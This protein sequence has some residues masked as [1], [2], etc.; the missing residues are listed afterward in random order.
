MKG[1]VALIF[2]IIALVII[3]G[4]AFAVIGLHEGLSVDE[5]VN[6][7]FHKASESVHSDNSEGSG[8]IVSQS[9]EENSQQGEGSYRQENY[10]DGGFR[11]FDTKT[12]EL[13]GS[14]YQS[15]Q[16]KLPSLE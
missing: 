7:I 3:M 14:S 12:G 16:A 6:K 11:Q 2:G 9:I 10:A 1:I 8:G 13:V 15:D 5:V 4:A